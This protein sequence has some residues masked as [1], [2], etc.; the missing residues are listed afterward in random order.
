MGLTIPI[1][2]EPGYEHAPWFNSII[3]GASTEARRRGAVCQTRECAADRLAY[4]DLSFIESPIRPVILVGSGDEWLSNVKSLCADASLRPIIAGNSADEGAFF[5]I[6]TVTINRSHA[7]AGLVGELCASGR[8]RLALV[9]SLPDSRID[10]QRRQLFSRIADMYGLYRPEIFY[11]QTDGFA[12]CL[13]RFGRDADRFD[14]VFFTNDLVALCFAP[15]AAAMG[16]VIPRDLVPVG[17]GDL[18]LS[19]AMLPQLFSF[20]LDFNMV[21]RCAMKTALELARSPEQLS[22]KVELACGLCRGSDDCLTTPES[23]GEYTEAQAAY[24]DREYDA[25]CYIS[26]L[27]TAGDRLSLDIL[28]GMNSDLTY[29]DLAEKLFISESALRYRMKNILAGLRAASRADARSLTGR[30]TALLDLQENRRSS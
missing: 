26:R 27:Y 12:E 24:D 14:A 9:G 3:S 7:I 25:L 16:I 2:R 29:S 8:R 22:R 19:H 5:P 13:T 18:P 15:R 4:V 20:S 6:S 17:F 10:I 11:D 21:G 28:R 30:Y 1:L 23:A